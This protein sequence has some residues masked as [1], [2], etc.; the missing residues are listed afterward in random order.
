MNVALVDYGAGNLTSVI[1]ALEAVGATVDLVSE[2]P[3]IARAR[4][5]VIPGVG[6]FSATA[7]LGTD[8]IAAVRDAIDR[9]VPL[10]GICLGLQWL[11][12]GSA[13]S[14]DAPGLGF[15][16]GQ[17]FRIEGP[18]KVPHVGWNSLD[19]TG[20]D[21]R[22]F[23]GIPDGAS[24]YF[25]PTSIT[26]A[27]GFTMSAFKNPATPIAAMMMSARRQWAAVSFDREW[28]IVTVASA[29]FAF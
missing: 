16:S 13:E 26:V 2:A 4:A 28:Q 8:W 12:D 10:L 29:C 27:P 20:R 21:S 3:A 7:S 15:V 23:A 14:P 9:G 11:F 17:C 19:R 6:H 1:K 24:A 25:T 5:I 22:L 18:V